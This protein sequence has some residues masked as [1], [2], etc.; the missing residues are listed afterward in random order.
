MNVTDIRGWV[1][2]TLHNV[3]RPGGRP[4]APFFHWWR[5]RMGRRREEEQEEEIKLTLLRLVFC[6]VGWPVH[7]SKVLLTWT[8]HE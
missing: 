7:A 6:H 2:K 3:I 1:A 5:R 4:A 8:G